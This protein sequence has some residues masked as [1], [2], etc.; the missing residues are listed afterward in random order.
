MMFLVVTT[1]DD[2]STDSI[3]T[4]PANVGV[5]VAVVST[6]TRRYETTGG[7]VTS[8]NIRIKV[9]IF[10]ATVVVGIIVIITRHVVIGM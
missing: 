8:S 10:S 5:E 6:M 3:A 4:S 7:K 9:I 2:G 1:R